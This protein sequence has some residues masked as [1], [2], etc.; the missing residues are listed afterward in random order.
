MTGNISKL[1]EAFQEEEV[2]TEGK[3]KVFY[4][5]RDGLKGINCQL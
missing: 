1:K 2:S 4:F 5:Q 3:D